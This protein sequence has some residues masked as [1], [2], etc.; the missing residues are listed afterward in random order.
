M[1]KYIF[2]ILGL[3]VCTF[4]AYFPLERSI[5]KNAQRITEEDS[6][7]NRE[8]AI[9]Q[10]DGIF[11]DVGSTDFGCVLYYNFLPS[12]DSV[13]DTERDNLYLFGDLNN[14]NSFSEAKALYRISKGAIQGLKKSQLYSIVDYIIRDNNINGVQ[15]FTQPINGNKSYYDD[16]WGTGWAIGYAHRISDDSYM[17]YLIHPDKV[18]FFNSNNATN[19]EMNKAIELA[20]DSYTNKNSHL[21]RYLSNNNIQKFAA[22][23]SDRIGTPMY[24][25][26]EDST[27]VDTYVT[28]DTI[29][30]DNSAI[31]SIARSHVRKYDLHFSSDNTYFIKMS[32]INK[33][34]ANLITSLSVFGGVLVLILLILLYMYYNKLKN[35]NH[36]ENH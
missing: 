28:T 19:Y 14:N 27:F 15:K 13:S 20:F 9:S 6:I 33:H 23:V 12:L 17:C 22:L 16:I 35:V 31:V 8:E 4:C 25:F 2:I 32:Y 30:L 26:T 7:K 1:K 24:H 5:E 21:Y 34:R 29:K 36:T 10:L 3:I 18:G 11:K